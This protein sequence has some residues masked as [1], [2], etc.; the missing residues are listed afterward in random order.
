[1]FQWSMGFLKGWRV[2]KLFFQLATLENPA[3]FS[4]NSVT[5]TLC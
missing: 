2:H 5:Y 1:M 4:L 3:T